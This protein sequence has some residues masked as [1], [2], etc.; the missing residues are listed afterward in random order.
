MLGWPASS[1]NE[2]YVSPFIYD[3]QSNVDTVIYIKG[4]TFT[5]DTVKDTTCTVM[6]LESRITMVIQFILFLFYS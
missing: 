1:T 2:M 5:V 6:D 4:S 3:V